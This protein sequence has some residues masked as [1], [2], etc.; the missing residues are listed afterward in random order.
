MG[1]IFAPIMGVFSDDDEEGG[2][3][4][5]AQGSAADRR[6]YLY[7]YNDESNVNATKDAKALT[8]AEDSEIAKKNAQRKKELLLKQQVKSV[9]TGPLGLGGINNGSLGL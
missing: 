8:S 9:F 7:G 1:E 2:G 5:Y 6:K 4:Q 3:A